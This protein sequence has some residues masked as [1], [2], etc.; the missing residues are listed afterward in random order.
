M[1]EDGIISDEIVQPFIIMQ[2][3][4]SIMKEKKT[5]FFNDNEGKAS[6]FK[7]PNAFKFF[8]KV[9]QHGI[10]RVKDNVLISECLDPEYQIRKKAVNNL[11]KIDD[12]VDYKPLYGEKNPIKDDML[13]KQLDFYCDTFKLRNRKIGR[14][15]NVGIAG[16]RN[17]MERAN[18]KLST[19]TSIVETME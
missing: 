10:S 8:K 18:S 15:R 5:G 7:T 12:D 2:P 11:Q 4:Y 16:G 14:E 17:S 19:R 13:S 3:Q 9:N 6:K 1:P